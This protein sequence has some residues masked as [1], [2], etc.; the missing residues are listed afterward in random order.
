MKD[1]TNNNCESI[2]HQLKLAVQWKAHPLVDL[3]EKLQQIVQAQYKNVKRSLLGLGDF[4]LCDEYSCHQKSIDSWKN[5]SQKQKQGHLI[6]FYRAVKLV[7]IS[8]D[9]SMGVLHAQN[10]GKKPNQIKRK[11]TAWT[12]TINK[13]PKI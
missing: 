10:G 12:T 7:I 8:T 3:I 2:N 4:Q 11:R 6:C 9:G 13:K 5:L 1:W